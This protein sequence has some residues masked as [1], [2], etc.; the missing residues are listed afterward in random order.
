MISALVLAAGDPIPS[1][2]IRQFL[3]V[4]VV[5]AADAGA[6]LADE[7]GIGIDVLVGDNDSIAADLLKTLRRSSTR[8]EEHPKGKDQ[9]DLDLAIEVACRR[10]AS[11]IIVAGGGG[12]RLDHLLGNAAVIAGRTDCS[13]TWVLAE[14]LAY[15]VHDYRTIE[16]DPGITVSVLPIGDDAR[17]VTLIGLKW[18]L[19]NTDLT[20]SSSLGISNIALH[21]S[22]TVSVTRGT[23]LVIVDR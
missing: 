14:E 6:H 13:I 1:D 5:I 23:V 18:P 8:I 10:G 17:G 7:V 15:P 16:V 9:T 21:T 19:T 2:R 20:N 22:I 3:P 11:D 12:G 4:D